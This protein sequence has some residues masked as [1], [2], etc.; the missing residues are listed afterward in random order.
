M[1]VPCYVSP[2]PREELRHKFMVR[3]PPYGEFGT[4]LCNPAMCRE[5]YRERA[6]EEKRP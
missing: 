4:M 3:R 5:C 2:L 6:C 1:K